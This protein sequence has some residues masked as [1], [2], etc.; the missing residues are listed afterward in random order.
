[1]GVTT[2]TFTTGSGPVVESLPEFSGFAQHSDPGPFETDIVGSFLIP[3]D[4][5]AALI[6]GTFGNSV[7]NSSAGTNVCLGDGP[8]FVS[9]TPLPPSFYLLLTAFMALGFV[10][11]RRRGENGTFGSAGFS[12]A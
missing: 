1:L 11:Y 8:C 12:A 3:L 7:V 10:V 5:T 6:S 2:I 4:A 9:A